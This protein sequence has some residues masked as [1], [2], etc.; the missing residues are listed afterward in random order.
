M[1][2]TNDYRIIKENDDEY[3]EKLREY[4]GMPKELFVKGTL[5][6]PAKPTAAIVGARMCSPYGRLQAFRFAKA[7]SENG[8][9]VISGLA[10]GIDTQAHLGALEGAAPTFAVL[11]CGLDICYPRSNNALRERM[12]RGGGGLL[13]E[14]PPGSAPMSYHFP[15]R[16]RIISALSDLVLVVEAR[17]SSGSLITASYAMEQGK[18]VYAIPGA[19]QEPLSQGTNQLIFDGAG[20]A[21]SPE[22]LLS[23]LGIPC[24]YL[25]GK[26]KTNA[27]EG[28]SGREQSVLGDVSG[29]EMGLST[30][31]KKQVLECIGTGAKTADGICEETGLPVPLVICLLVQMELEGKVLYVGGGK[32]GIKKSTCISIL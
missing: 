13:T 32:Y 27:R 29:A 6:D 18:T 16:N 20:A 25:N 30:E 31:R 22:I 14:F 11:G 1:T 15:I 12:L 8:V 9:Q 5:P 2:R 21:I 4:P 7:L 19:V 23:E 26:E 28:I 10:V 3:P 24:R 17:K